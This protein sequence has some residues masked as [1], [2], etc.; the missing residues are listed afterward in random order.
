VTSPGAA[1]AV[2]ADAA[3][4]P[5]LTGYDAI[6][7]HVRFTPFKRRFA[8]KL[9]QI[10]IDIDAPETAA[11]GL[12]AF[13]VNR[14]GLFS[15]FD[16]DHGDRSGVRLRGWAE[17]LWRD[18]GID[19]AG[20]PIRLLTF[21]RM[22]GFVFNPISVFF[23]YGPDGR[24]RG[25]IYEV[26]NTFGE[27]HAYVAATEGGAVESHT[28]PKRF[29]VSP[30]KAVIGDYRF[31]LSAPDDRFYLFVENQIDGATAHV[32]SLLGKR[33]SATNAW[34]VGVFFRLPMM[35]MKVVAGI[36]WEALWIWLRGARYHD[37]PTTPTQPATH[38]VGPPHATFN[39]ISARKASPPSLQPAMEQ[40]NIL[41]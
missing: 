27:T 10:L 19:L 31:R 9:A 17:G 34:F 4:L 25:V 22:L 28:A 37:K 3:L 32:A 6:T 5:A 18:A 36:H 35:T 23:G 41:G 11:R 2:G 15:Y 40:G 13:T 20:G 8:Y 29:H 24:L 1:G 30:F 39:D 7:A 12:W 33:K 21:P 26:N 38:A 16:K 14:F